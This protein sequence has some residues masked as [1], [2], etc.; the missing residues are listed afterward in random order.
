MISK[1]QTLQD[2]NFH[3]KIVRLKYVNK[4]EVDADVTSISTLK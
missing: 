2:T 3:S 4:K 1:Q